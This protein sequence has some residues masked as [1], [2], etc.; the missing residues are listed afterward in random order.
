[1]QTKRHT[2][3]AHWTEETEDGEILLCADT[4]RGTTIVI[5]VTDSSYGGAIRER[6]ADVGREG[7]S[8]G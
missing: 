6:A 2:A 4:D 5:D 8:D 1:M 7:G 3:V